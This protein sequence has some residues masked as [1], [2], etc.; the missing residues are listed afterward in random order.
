MRIFVHRASE[1]LTDHESHGDGLISFSILNA[2]AERG[3]EI[4]AFTNRA[5]VNQCS[6]NLHVKVSKQHIV[7]ANSLSP[8]EYSWRAE[9]WM[10]EVI[11]EKPFDIV[12]RMHPYGG[13]CPYP[14][15]THG[16]K[17]V[18]GPLFYSWPESTP[19]NKLGMPRFGLSIAGLVQPIAEK[20][21]RKLL[22]TADLVICS[23]NIHAHLI[24]QLY[25]PRSVAVVPVIVEPSNGEAGAHRR[26]SNTINL[27]F[28]ANLAPN[29]NPKVF[30]ET[31][32]ILRE[33]GL[34]VVG[35]IIGN[36]SDRVTLEEY[37]KT[38]NILSYIKFLGKI[39]NTEVY[40]QLASADF[41]LSASLGEPY[42]RSIVEAMSV[43]TPAICHKSGGP[44]D[45]IEHEVNG[46][47]VS[48][49]EP[50]QYA[51]AIIRH[52]TPVTWQKL[53][54]GALASAQEWTSKAVIDKLEIILIS[55]CQ[56]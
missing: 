15:P 55:M 16:A 14:P 27:C 39:P 19:T 47:L 21:W 3:H 54:E 40:Q 11:T 5:P 33:R 20:G 49:L 25:S 26:L 52:S 12:W 17:M 6:P 44:A 51:E 31:I 37:C 7:P 45:F 53:S 18:V 42:G 36:G 43:G 22:R 9:Q 29:K 4:Y 50:I 32:K 35:T 41:L 48:E 23:T 1:C 13:G 38:Q 56:K 34:S 46:L 24:G 2:L 30:C 28:V 8:W 10:N